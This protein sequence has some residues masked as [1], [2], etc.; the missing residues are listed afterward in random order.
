[1]DTT[2]D[3]ADNDW[4]FS[5][6]RF[7]QH[8]TIADEGF[9][10]T[11]LASSSGSQ[12]ATLDFTPPLVDLAAM[13]DGTALSNWQ[14]AMA[15]KEDLMSGTLGVHKTGNRLA[16][17]LRSR[18]PSWAERISLRADVVITHTGFTYESRT[19]FPGR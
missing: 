13:P 15:G 16:L 19:T 5:T 6:G 18:S 3:V 2:L 12:S 10:T 11:A 1:M 17:E 7:H 14:L 8:T 4:V 9:M